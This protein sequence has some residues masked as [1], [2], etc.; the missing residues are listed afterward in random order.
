MRHERRCPN[1]DARA[2][3][4]RALQRTA[5]RNVAGALMGVARWARNNG[6]PQ[7]AEDM[8]RMIQK[9]VRL[10]ELEAGDAGPGLKQC[11][12]GVGTPLIKRFTYKKL[13]PLR[14]KGG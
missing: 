14:L 2:A 8:E 6:M 12:Q 10:A 1:Q 5:H 3:E 7:R 13:P 4:A 11:L 9:Y